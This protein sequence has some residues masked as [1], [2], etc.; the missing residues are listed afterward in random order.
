MAVFSA[1]M[2]AGTYSNHEPSRKPP[3]IS[4]ALDFTGA[5][6]LPPA[7]LGINSSFEPQGKTRPVS[8]APSKFDSVK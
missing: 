7:C 6:A 5:E 8:K 1:D 4:A 3:K 2:V